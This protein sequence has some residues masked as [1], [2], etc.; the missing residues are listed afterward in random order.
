MVVFWGRRVGPL[1]GIHGLRIGAMVCEVL[2]RYVHTGLAV[3]QPPAMLRA[4]GVLK[5]G[6][7]LLYS[8]PMAGVGFL[9]LSFFYSCFCVDFTVLLIG[10]CPP[11]L[12]PWPDVARRALSSV[13]SR[14]LLGSERQFELALCADGDP[15]RDTVA[16]CFRG[17]LI[18]GAWFGMS[19]RRADRAGI[20]TYCSCQRY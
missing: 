2:V 14:I 3:P 10:R 18:R 5:L 4:W 20:T 7:E 9:L 17:P 19:D 11:R 16:K 13:A 1:G 15:L 12:C 8:N 6:R